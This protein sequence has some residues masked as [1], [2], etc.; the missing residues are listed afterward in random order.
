MSFLTRRHH[1]KSNLLVISERRPHFIIN[2]REEITFHWVDLGG[3]WWKF[4]LYPKPK[5]SYG[6][7][8]TWRAGHLDQVFFYWCGLMANSI[9]LDSA[10]YYISRNLS[11]IA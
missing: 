5:A 8:S 3:V 2:L 10:Y 9:D 4:Y 7:C 1:F 11:M 6:P